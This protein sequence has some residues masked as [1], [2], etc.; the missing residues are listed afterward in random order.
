[1]FC[2]INFQASLAIWVAIQRFMGDLETP[3]DGANNRVGNH[4]IN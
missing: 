3:K 2:N 4:D 1:M